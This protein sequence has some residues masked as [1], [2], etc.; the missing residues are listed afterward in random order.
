MPARSLPAEAMLGL[1]RLYRLTLS[2]LIGRGCRHE[3]TCSAFALETIGEHGAWAGGWMAAAR[4]CRCR[5]GGSWGYD[6]APAAKPRH[7][8]WWKP[9]SYGDWRGGFRAPPESLEFK[10]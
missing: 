6:P 9:W 4:I 3:P 1:V 2:P 7:A 10:S 8:R 5:P